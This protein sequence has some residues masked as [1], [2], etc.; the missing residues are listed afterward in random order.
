MILYETL[1]R[2]IQTHDVV[3]VE[4]YDGLVFYLFSAMNDGKNFLGNAQ[5]CMAGKNIKVPI[6]TIRE[7]LP[8]D[9]T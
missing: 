1:A 5:P 8:H 6:Y 7:I 9:P 3:K 2:R 4:C